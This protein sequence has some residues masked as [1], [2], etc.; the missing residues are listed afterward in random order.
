[1]GQTEVSK[2]SRGLQENVAGALCYLAGLVTGIVFLVLEKENRFVRFHA[3]QS[4]VVSI[5]LMVVM[6]VLGFIPIIGWVINMLL[7]IGVFILWIVMMLN[8]YRGRM[9]KLPVAGNIAESQA[10]KVS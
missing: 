1:M 6:I 10:N 3:I 7:G 9:M 4:I 5:A 8:A 2:T